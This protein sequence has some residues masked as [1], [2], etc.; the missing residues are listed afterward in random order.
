MLFF[1][2]QSIPQAPP[3]RSTKHILFRFAYKTNF[4]S[5]IAVKIK[6]KRQRRMLHMPHSNFVGHDTLGRLAFFVR[7]S[8]IPSGRTTVPKGH[9]CTHCDC[10][11]FCIW[12]TVFSFANQMSEMTKAKIMK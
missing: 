3:K 2:E 5:F 4:C 9:S 10:S 6:A 8:S 7:V 1:N 11:V 12:F